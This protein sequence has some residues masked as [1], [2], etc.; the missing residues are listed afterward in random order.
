VEN[1]VVRKVKYFKFN[2]RL[3]YRDAK[4]LELCKTEEITRHFTN[5]L[6]PQHNGISKRMNKT[7]L[8][9][10]R[11]MRLNAE[12]SKSLWAE[13]VNYT[14]FITNWSSCA[15]IDFKVLE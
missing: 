13:A 7:L 4:F 15:T 1:Q 8:E 5:K 10:A 3:E 9:H 12:L 14:S 11:C 6:T 2:N